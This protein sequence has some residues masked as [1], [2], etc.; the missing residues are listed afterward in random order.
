MYH[1][2]K[3]RQYLTLVIIGLF[4]LRALVLNVIFQ[5]NDG[6]DVSGVWDLFSTA[7]LYGAINLIVIFALW[8]WSG[9]NLRGL[10][11]RKEGAGK[12]LL[13]GML[14]GLAMLLQHYLLTG[15]LIRSFV[16]ANAD[17][18]IDMPLLFQNTADIPFWILLSVFK[19]GFEEE[20]WR[21]FEMNSFKRVFG[22]AGLVF[23]LIAGAVFFGLQHSYQ[24]LDSVISTGFDG[25][26]YGLIYLRRRSVIEAMAAHATFDIISILAGYYIYAG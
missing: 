5:V 14:F 18:G 26:L 25:L 1:S 8:Y 13:I 2:V 15:P 22:K 12:H 3:S 11:L 20:L 23:G 16:P 7:S 24:G 19:G 6:D 10:G 21:S 17:Q 9:G 4:W